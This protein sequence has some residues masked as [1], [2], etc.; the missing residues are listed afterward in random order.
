LTPF[1]TGL[2]NLTFSSHQKRIRPPHL[3]EAI[4]NALISQERIGWGHLL[5]SFLSTEWGSLARLDMFDSRKSDAVKGAHRI[6]KCLAA[7]HA[8]TR[9]LWLAR[10]TILHAETEATTLAI[11]RTVRISYASMI[12]TFAIEIFNT[13]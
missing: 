9:Q 8:F 7:I 5:K 11:A 10:N 12:D 3:Q 13:S 6:R 4:H 1:N 2:L